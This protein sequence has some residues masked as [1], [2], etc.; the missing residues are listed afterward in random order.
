MSWWS[1]DPRLDIILDLIADTLTQGRQIMATL[2]DISLAIQRQTTVEKSVVALLHQLSS[3][4]HDAIAAEDPVAVQ[5]VVDLIDQNSKTLSDAVFANTPLALGT[6][7]PGIP[8][9]APP[10]IADTTANT[11]PPDAQPS[12]APPSDAPPP[13]AVPVAPDAPSPNG[14]KRG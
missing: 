14:K 3:Q 8:E 5:A 13:D 4:L 12:D 11:Q 1:H 6:A 7:T 10:H 9:L 2:S